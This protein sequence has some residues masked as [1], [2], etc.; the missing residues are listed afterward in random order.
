VQLNV[1]ERRAASIAEQL[2]GPG[3]ELDFDQLLAKQPGRRDAV[4]GWIKAMAITNPIDTAGGIYWLLTGA[5]AMGLLLYFRQRNF[6]LPHPIGLVMWVN[7]TMRSFWFSIMLGWLF[8]TLVSRY[9][10]QNT[11]RQFRNFF[12][13]LIVGELVMCLF[14]VDLN[15]N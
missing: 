11:Y 3:M 2:S 4:F 13:G 5:T 6:W 9:G 14:G 15:R 10:D 8:K 12:I 1:F 7:P